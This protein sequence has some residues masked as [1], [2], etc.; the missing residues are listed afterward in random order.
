MS[1][2]SPAWTCRFEPGQMLISGDL[3]RAS[4]DRVAPAL[5]EEIIGAEFD[6]HLGQVRRLD[7]AGLA[8]LTALQARAEAKGVRLRYTHAPSAMRQ[9]IG[10]Y[11]LADL[12][13]LKSGL[14][15]LPTSG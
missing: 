4:L 1:E 13:N 3:V 15:D 9:M 6:V 14:D 10:V 12:M 5:P 11:G 2:T 7:T 8:W